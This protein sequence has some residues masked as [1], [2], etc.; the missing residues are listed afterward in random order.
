M[1]A[2]KIIERIDDLPTLP[3]S[4]YRV[5]RVADDPYSSI[6][7]IAKSVECDQVLTAKILRLINSAFYGISRKITKVEQSITL[8]G[9][10]AI[11]NLVLAT[12]IFQSL[13]EKN[14][15][16]GLWIH[17]LAVAVTAKIIAKKIFYRELEEIFVCGL[18]HDI[19][20]VVEYK[21]CRIELEKAHS[22]SLAQKKFYW[23]I[24]KELFDCSHERVGQLLLNKWKMPEKY[25]KPV[26][27]HHHPHP[28]RDFALETTIVFLA[29]ALIRTL[30]IGDSF[31]GNLV[32]KIKKSQLELA[33]LK[34]L[35][36]KD[37]EKTVRLE[38]GEA[39][40]I[41]LESD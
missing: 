2:S 35:L 20:M 3:T 9:I 21:I 37:I 41:F 24:E 4:Y 23:E 17:A 19:G 31:D 10:N 28:G 27:F 34:N 11:K 30:G 40:Q 7:E 32:P 16:N 29:D 1:I 39:T 18:L 8:L 12:A 36:N 33:G 22:T 38:V 14:S 26:G 5:T 6:K 13:G 25:S 15:L